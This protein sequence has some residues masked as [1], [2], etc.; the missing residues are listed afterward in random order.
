[1]KNLEVLYLKS[2]SIEQRNLKKIDQQTI[3]LNKSIIIAKTL[4]L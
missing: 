2:R 4:K 3:K 1:M